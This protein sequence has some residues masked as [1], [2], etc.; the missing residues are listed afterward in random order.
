ML[1]QGNPAISL[2]KSVCN[3]VFKVNLPGQIFL[4]YMVRLH[5]YLESTRNHIVVSLSEEQWEGFEKRDR[6]TTLLLH[7]YVPTIFLCRNNQPGIHPAFLRRGI[8]PRVPLHSPGV[9][10][11]Y[12]L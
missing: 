7:T 10:A 4:L 11:R 9:Q 8:H 6:R 5:T 3:R 1:R 12:S 2:N